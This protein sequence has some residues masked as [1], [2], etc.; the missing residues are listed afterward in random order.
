MGSPWAQVSFRL[1]VEG[2]FVPRGPSAEAP[3]A[4]HRRHQAKRDMLSRAW[5]KGR[6]GLLQ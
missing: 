3:A 4:V 6:A 5:L 2:C 1:A